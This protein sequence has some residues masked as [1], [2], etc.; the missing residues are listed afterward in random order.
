MSGFDWTYDIDA[1]TIYVG[2]K[3]RVD[4]NSVRSSLGYMDNVSEEN[5][6]NGEFLEF[7][8]CWIGLNVDE[9]GNTYDENIALGKPIIK[10]VINDFKMPEHTTYHVGY[11]QFL[12]KKSAYDLINK[13]YWGKL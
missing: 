9:E 4:I 6:S 13:G 12:C 8:I 11:S 2:S 10:V 3:F 7:E 5:W 1:E